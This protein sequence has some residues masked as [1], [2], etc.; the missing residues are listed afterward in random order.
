MPP[1]PKHQEIKILNK[2]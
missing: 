2:G 1:T